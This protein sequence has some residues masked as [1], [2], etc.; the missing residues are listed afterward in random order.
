MGRR[1]P[2]CGRGMFRRKALMKHI[3]THHP[4]YYKEWYEN[5]GVSSK[6]KIEKKERK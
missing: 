4:S 3:K 2:V 6:M 5:Y 1:C